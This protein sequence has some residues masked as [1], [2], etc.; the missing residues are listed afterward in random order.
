MTN[1]SV[2]FQI[3]T[4]DG[5][6]SFCKFIKYYS[7]SLTI[8]V[9]PVSE[10]A[11]SIATY[12]QNI[13]NVQLVN[14]AIYYKDN[15]DISLYIPKNIYYNSKHFSLLPMNDWGEKENMLEYKAKTI[16]FNTI[17]RD[18]NISE[19]EYLQID[20][21]GFDTEIIEMIDFSKIR[22]NVLRF[23]KWGFAKEA[24]T[25]HNESLSDRLGNEG[26][27]LALNKLKENG[28]T[29]FSIKDEDGNDYVAV[30]NDKLDLV[31]KKMY[32]QN[33]TSF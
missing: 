8:L 21:E 27:V 20:T 4:N 30:K 5:N 29:I 24:F 9:E 7:P 31:G 23:E 32:L 3:G 25:K 13:P 12:Y 11:Q 1:P 16:T 15:E 22:I 33:L 19:I 2:F 26:M 17:C 14:R 6:D 10:L 28:Y 18:L